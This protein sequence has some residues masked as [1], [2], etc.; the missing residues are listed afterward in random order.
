MPRR[1]SES[2]HARAR[3]ILEGGN[4]TD[5]SQPMPVLG[6]AG[7]G[8][9]NRPWPIL[10]PDATKLS[11]IPGTQRPA[12]TSGTGFASWYGNR[13][14]IGFV[15]PEDKGRQGISERE[16]GIALGSLSTLGK[17]HYLTDPHTG[18]THVV[19]Q[20]DTGPNIRTQKL[21]DIHASQLAKMGYTA[22]TFPSG[23]GL[24]QVKPTG[25]E[26]AEPGRGGAFDEGGI[27]GGGAPP[28]S[29]PGFRGG[30]QVAEEQAITE[31]A[32]TA[33]GQ[34]IAQRATHD[35]SDREWSQ[36]IPM[37]ELT[38]EPSENIEDRRKELYE[39]Q[40]YVSHPGVEEF[41]QRGFKPVEPSF[42]TDWEKS[43]AANPSLREVEKVRAG[44]DRFDPRTGKPLAR[45]LDAAGPTVNGNGKLD[46]DVNAPRNVSVT[47]E[48]G[49]V[50]NKTETTRQLEPMA[51]E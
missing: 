40:P 51:E 34:D 6:P 38:R 50:F 20:T 2:E 30:R 46:V 45:E 17:Y 5:S 26:Q 42:G 4:V 44:P 16:Q 47:A 1:L 32:D 33:R 7:G 25:F 3:Q 8:K 15:D 41:Y 35:F 19:K 29:M 27:V 39:K 28:T 10:P 21:T 31:R 48:G 18:L 13:P 11:A 37:R 9:S 49:G 14:D 24:W 36:R 23:K 43:I 22:K 12:Q